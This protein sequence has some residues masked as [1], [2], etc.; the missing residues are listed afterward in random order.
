VISFK[1]ILNEEINLYRGDVILK[2]KREV[3]Q[4]DI[5]NQIRA[6]PNV[7][8]VAPV[9]DDYLNSQKTDNEE[10]ALVKIKFINSGDPKNDLDSIK[11]KALTGGEDYKKIDGLLQFIVR[12]NTIIPVNR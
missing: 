6:L 7:I 3:S 2:N 12:P 10:Y 8:V 9:Y 11:S 1:T 5:F 4:K